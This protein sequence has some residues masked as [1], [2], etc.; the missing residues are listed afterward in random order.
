V[1]LGDGVGRVLR[2]GSARKYASVVSGG[3]GA[4]IGCDH[5]VVVDFLECHAYLLCSGTALTE[6]VHTQAH[7]MI[8]AIC[9]Q[10]KIESI[11]SREMNRAGTRKN[12][13][14]CLLGVPIREK[15]WPTIT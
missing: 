13:V 5:R 8:R 6:T 3:L 15:S 1:L 2:L 4:I 12:A 7:C 11:N 14:K 10:T 9:S